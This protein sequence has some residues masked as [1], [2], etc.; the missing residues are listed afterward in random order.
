MV[1]D[2]GTQRRLI[3]LLQEEHLELDFWRQRM[4]GADVADVYYPAF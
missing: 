4:G 1:R 3:K 2:K